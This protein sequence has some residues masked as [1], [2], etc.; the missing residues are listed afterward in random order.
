MTPITPV[1][2]ISPPSQEFE[3]RYPPKPPERPELSPPPSEPEIP[4]LTAD[5]Q[6][7]RLKIQIDRNLRPKQVSPSINR[8]LDAA[9][10]PREMNIASLAK[11]LRHL[12]AT[13]ATKADEVEKNLAS[14]SP[15]LLE[16]IKHQ[17]ES[18]KE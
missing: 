5:E 18:D 3:R 16:L 17:M 15:E 14:L 4:P 8:Y 11:Q 7:R 2:R 13:D 12:R 6:A 10:G 1:E 9:G